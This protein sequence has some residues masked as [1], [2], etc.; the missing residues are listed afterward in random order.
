MIKL[1]WIL[2]RIFLLIFVIWGI[3]TIVF[4]IMSVVPRNPAVAMSGSR[5]TPEQVE[6]F[7]ERWGLDRPIP[8]RYLEFY[9]YLF[10]G[11]LG[12][13]IRTER[14]VV[15]EIKNFFPA[16]LELATFAIIISLVIGVPLGILSAIKRDKIIDQFTR[17]L[18]LI[19][20]STPNFW[21][22]LILLIIFYYFLGW[23]G[24]CRISSAELAPTHITGLFL[25]DS[26]IELNWASFIDS[27]K[28]LV[29]PAFALG[30]FGIGIVTRMM[31]S[32]TLDVL[33]K[34]FVKAAR[35]R[36]LSIS[37]V[38][39]RHVLKNAFIPVITIIGILYGSY[40]AGVIVIEVVFGWPGLGSFAYT[41][42]LKADSPA[43]MGVVLVI[44]LFYSMINLF[45]DIIYRY[46]DPRIGFE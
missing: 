6:K 34:D 10:K 9:Q 45:V 3:T 37:K 16:T 26:I 30:F 32:S 20:V 13:S 36:G 23:A 1:L 35:S 14:P 7:N 4:I 2:K 21:L 43:I 11:D 42:I 31:R 28:H 18:S 8:V 22:G 41:S 24:P 25:I 12:T 19:G 27:L 46:L 17:V 15:T 44:S 33:N 39:L 29:L 5:A 38:M 40:L